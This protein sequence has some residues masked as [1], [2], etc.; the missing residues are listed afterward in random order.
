MAGD[1]AQGRIPG[2]GCWRGA[3]PP[4]TD[5]IRDQKGIA[6]IGFGPI[7]I[8]F[9]KTLDNAGIQQKPLRM[10]PL[11]GQ[12]LGQR[13]KQRPMVDRGGFQS[14]RQA[15]D[16]DG[17]GGEPVN[18]L[19]DA[20]PIIEDAQAPLL[21]PFHRHGAHDVFGLTYIDPYI[22]CRYH[23]KH[24]LSGDMAT[25]SSRSGKGTGRRPLMGDATSLS[26]V[27]LHRVV[28]RHRCQGCPRRRAATRALASH[29]PVDHAVLES[30][31]TPFGCPARQGGAA[32]VVRIRSSIIDRVLQ[33]KTDISRSGSIGMRAL[34]RARIPTLG[35]Y[36]IKKQVQA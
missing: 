2:I 34:A 27:T 21:N 36:F 29:Q 15:V 31:L 1:D 30:L 35:T 18:Q 3:Q 19:I 22:Q 28:R 25:D 20:R 23:A 16:V 9:A 8:G 13:L 26:A 11:Q 5:G 4:K 6:G 12:R 24:L 32:S 10:P 33:C 17:L 7:H 14:D